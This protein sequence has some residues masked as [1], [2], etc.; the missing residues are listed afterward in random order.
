MDSNTKELLEQLAA[1][2]GTTSQYLWS[3]LL[4]QAPIDATISLIQIIFTLLLGYALFKL[5]V[6]FNESEAYD[7]DATWIIMGCLVII[8]LI[9][10]CIAIACISFVV[11]G[12]FNPEYWA[13]NRVL[14]ACK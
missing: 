11:N 5:H 9:F 12:Y 1:K 4:K 8:Y 7:N 3:I 6:K 2:M 10:L 13:L 14:D